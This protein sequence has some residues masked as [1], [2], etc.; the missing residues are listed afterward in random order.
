M[1]SR[2]GL[3]CV[4]RSAAGTTTR[5]YVSV[6]RPP[7]SYLKFQVPMP[8]EIRG[9]YYGQPVR[10]PACLHPTVTLESLSTDDA[11][12]YDAVPSR[13]ALRVGN[14]LVY[15]ATNFLSWKKHT[16]INRVT[17]EEGY[18]RRVERVVTPP[19]LP[20]LTYV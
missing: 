16:F 4:T 1:N 18:Y 20:P 10:I 12:I 9:D 3:R 2:P 15:R 13:A 5:T 19:S 17:K 14:K 8:T 11:V 6:T 7:L